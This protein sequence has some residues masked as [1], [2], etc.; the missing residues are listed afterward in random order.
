MEIFEMTM[1]RPSMPL[2]L[3]CAPSAL[4]PAAPVAV[5]AAERAPVS[6]VHQVSARAEL[7]GAAVRIEGTTGFKGSNVSISKRYTDGGSGVPP[8]GRPV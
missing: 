4:Q 2:T 6:L 8:R 1:T 5:L 7:G 3:A